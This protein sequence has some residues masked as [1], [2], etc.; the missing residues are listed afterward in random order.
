MDYV[1]VLSNV[2]YECTRHD[3]QSPFFGVGLP[4]LA[5]VTEDLT[6]NQRQAQGAT[7]GEFQ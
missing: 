6:V 5:T 4:G 1:H 7:N 3:S 2:N